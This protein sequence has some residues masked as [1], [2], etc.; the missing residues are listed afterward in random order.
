MSQTEQLDPSN[1]LQGVVVFRNL[2]EELT[3]TPGNYR[4]LDA[5]LKNIELD[6]QELIVAR[7]VI[8][9]CGCKSK[10]TDEKEV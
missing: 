7:S 6:L 3:M 10:P 8:E 4:L 1:T 9:K 5:Y 2:L